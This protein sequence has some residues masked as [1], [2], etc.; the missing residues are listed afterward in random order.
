MK[1]QSG[2]GFKPSVLVAES[3]DE[4]GMAI[5]REGGLEVCEAAELSREEFESR[6][7]D[8][9]ALIVRSKTKVTRTMLGM[10]SSLQVIGRAGVGVDSIDV[11]AAT[12]AG[13]LVLNTPDASTIATAEHTLAML[14][15]LC[16]RISAGQERIDNQHWS[17]Q[18]LTGIELAGKTLGIVGLGRIGA[19]VA[20]RARA[21]AMTVLAHDAVVSAARAD[22]LGVKL[23]PLDELLTRADFVT[24]HTPLTAQTENLIGARELGLMKPTSSII[25]CARGG[26]IDEGALLLALESGH[27]AGAALDVVA[28]EPPKSEATWALLHHPR[29][30]ATP[31]LGGSTKEAQEKIA[32]DLCRDVVAVL[33]GR[34]PSSA[35]N[36][37]VNVPQEIRPFAELAHRLGSIFPQICDEKSLSRF[38]IM[39]EGEL[40]G[41]E[42]LPFAV[43]FLVGLLPHLTEERVSA[44]NAL[45]VARR[46]GVLVETLGAPC[47]RGFAKALAVSGGRNGLAGTVVHGEQL[48][49]IDI[50]GFELDAALQGHLLL[51]RHH[52][53]PGIIGKVGTILGEAHINIFTMEVARSE[54]GD[55]ILLAAVDRVPDTEI[56]R[57]L[58]DI[59]DVESVRHVEL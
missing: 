11:Q 26:L 19:T 15:G 27:I 58:R 45:E 41:Y 52:D 20:T 30:V 46:L 47:E 33:R 1:L 7:P 6:L 22:S 24:L 49:L 8:A 10:A 40:A 32:R 3:L 12:N 51:T 13:I 43:S 56:L 4:S 50:D 5:L 38:D 34:P 21:F 42:G 48:R 59:E 31:H 17:A 44:V 2:V 29:V 25:N 55:A 37:P 9:Q 36:A 16:R 23:V 39:L 35:V 28:E 54:R 57:R 53:V 18:D 14:L